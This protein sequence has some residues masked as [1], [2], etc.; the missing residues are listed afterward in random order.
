MPYGFTTDDADPRVSI[1]KNQCRELLGSIEHLTIES[2][3]ARIEKLMS[4]QGENPTV[5][6]AATR[7]LTL[8]RVP[9]DRIA[10]AIG[11]ARMVGWAAQTIEQ[12]ESGIPLLPS[13]RYADEDDTVS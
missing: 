4:E 10:L 6:W 1:L 9:E 2:S 3:A 5:D 11:M 12:H 7:V 8:L 13:L